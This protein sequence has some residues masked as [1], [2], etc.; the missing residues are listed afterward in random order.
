MDE[1]RRRIV[2]A[3]LALVV[4]V[5]AVGLGAWVITRPPEPAP[6][7]PTTMAPAVARPQPSAPPPEPVLKPG[8]TAPLLVLMYHHIGDPPAGARGWH[9]DLYVSAKRLAQDLAQLQAS[10]CRV[11]TMA[12]AYRLIA[13]GRLPKQAVVLTFDDGYGDN[14]TIAGPV[15]QRYGMLAT[16]NVVVSKIGDGKHMN[17]EQLQALAH[18]GNDIGCH[19]LTHP[20]LRK[21]NEAQLETEVVAAKQQLE[22]VLG[23]PVLTYCYPD[24]KYDQRTLAAVRKADYKV[25]LTTGLTSGR[26]DTSRPFEVGRYRVTM[27]KPIPAGLL[28]SDTDT[29]E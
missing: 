23:E 29:H 3:V 19:S 16:F 28:R 15:L 22:A 6:P 14:V 12:Q 9:R 21:I 7:V 26:F 5:A 24:G 10:R 25:A 1:S 11:M 17:R 20:D 4:A 2:L 13:Q 8:E 27:R 18:A